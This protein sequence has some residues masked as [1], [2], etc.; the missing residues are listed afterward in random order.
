MV[1]KEYDDQKT[2]EE[3]EEGIDKDAVRGEGDYYYE[4]VTAPRVSTGVMSLNLNRNQRP[5]P[6]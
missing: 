6:A 1:E 5:L 4:Y 3:E 2:S